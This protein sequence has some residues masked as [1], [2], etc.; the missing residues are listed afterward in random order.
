GDFDISQIKDL[1]FLHYKEQEDFQYCDSW[2]LIDVDI[3]A[4]FG[5]RQ[6]VNIVLPQYLID[7]IDQRVANNPIY[8]DRS[9]FL[10]VAS[11]RE[12]S[13]SL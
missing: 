7:R 13:S 8:K 1:G 2:L 10:A 11:Q 4:Y 9:H 5:K 6:R 12:L 3:T